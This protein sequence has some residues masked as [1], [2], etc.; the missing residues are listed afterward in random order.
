MNKLTLLLIPALFYLN[1]CFT[2]S[3]VRLISEAQ[4]V[5]LANQFVVVKLN[6]KSAT[7]VSLKYKNQEL[8][9][10][11]RRSTW[12]CVGLS[13]NEDDIKKYSGT[14]FY[15]VRIDP[16]LNGG[17]RAEVSFKYIYNPAD[18]SSLPLDVDFRFSLGKQDKGVYLSALWH[19]GNRYPAFTLGQGRMAFE[20][21]PSIFDFYTVDSR[22]Q[23]MMATGEDWNKGTQLNV[24]EARRLHTGIRKDSVEHKYDYAAILAQTEAWGWTS[25]KYK[26]GLWMINPSFEYINGGPT[27]VGNTGHVSTILLNHWQDGHYGGGPII[28]AKDEEWKKFVGPFF[29]YCNE[30]PTHSDMWNDALTKARSEKQQWP[31]VWVREMEYPAAAQR[32]AVSGKLMIHDPQAKN[33][34]N[35]WVG[36]AAPDATVEQ[37]GGMVSAWQ[38]ETKGYQYWAKASNNLTFSIPNV[39]PGT[40]TLFAFADNILGEYKKTNI[41]I[42]AGKTLQLGAVNWTP[43][44]H[45]RQIWE[46]GVPNRSASEFR[47]GDHYWQWGLYLKYPQE[48]PN[49]VQYTIGKSNWSTDWNYCQPA[50]INADYKVVRGTTQTIY[51][52]IPQHLKGIATLRMAICGSRQESIT[53]LLNDKVIGNTGRLPNMGVM[54]RDGIRGLQVEKDIAFDASLL[55]PGANTIKLKLSDIKNW[56]NGVLYDYLRLEIKD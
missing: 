30:G 49:D 22:R 44:R 32:G 42:E 52:N 34:S 21:N 4:Y 15:S 56:P 43:V 27:Q 55:K 12:N 39:R 41:T 33:V 17:E 23:R 45:G 11:A 24:K 2:Q 3:P 54:H 14:P 29:L 8:L 19:H 1:V 40:Y 48:F 31:F 10:P 16:S 9:T 37:F 50:V 26:I 36:L 5:T 20:L 47:H 28:L 25:T 13:E 18:T 7:I 6:K 46:I 53:V 38:R 51:F 35:L